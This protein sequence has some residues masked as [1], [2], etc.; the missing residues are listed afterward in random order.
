VTIQ[1]ADIGDLTIYLI[2]PGR[3]VTL[4]AFN[5]N[6]VPGTTFPP[7]ESLGRFG[8]TI[9]DDQATMFIDDTKS[10]TEPPAN[11]ADGGEAFAPYA[12]PFKPQSGTLRGL[13]GRI[14]ES[15]CLLIKDN[16]PPFTAP[17]DVPDTGSLTSWGI[18]VKLK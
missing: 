8:P 5:D 18:T 12:G 6:N 16:D 17:G 3:F 2:T 11:P 14:A 15:Y 9:F 10:A 4:S 7:F 1:H 13:G